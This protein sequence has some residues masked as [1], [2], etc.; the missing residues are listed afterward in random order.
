M[1]LKN[2]YENVE[3]HA[4]KIAE[5]IAENE[6]LARS[7]HKWVLE[8]RLGVMVYHSLKLRGL[9]PLVLPENHMLSVCLTPFSLIDKIKDMFELEY[10]IS[11]VQKV[12]IPTNL[13]S[14]FARLYHE[15]LEGLGDDFAYQTQRELAYTLDLI[16]ELDNTFDQAYS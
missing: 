3:V 13:Y 12:V 1:R 7:G 6:E 11:S 16:D 4:Q 5:E 2:K 9:D 14:L 8:P 15:V 10:H